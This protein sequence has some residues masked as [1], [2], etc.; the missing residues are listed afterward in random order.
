[1]TFQSRRPFLVSFL[2]A[3]L[4]ACLTFHHISGLRR[5]V[6]SDDLASKAAAAQEPISLTPSLNQ[7]E[8]ARFA[9]AQEMLVVIKTGAT[10]IHQKLPVHFQ[11]T[12]Q[13]IPHFVIYSDMPEEING[14]QVHDVLASISPDHKN[15]PQG[16]R[17]LPKS[18][19]I[20]NGGP[21][22]IYRNC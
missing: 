7:P 15:N 11:T 22:C 18:P 20:P 19:T 16:L 4:V 17:S 13:C 5:F 14:H 3:S 10:E 2:I 8:C 6:V 21:Q 9:P 12:L 1:M